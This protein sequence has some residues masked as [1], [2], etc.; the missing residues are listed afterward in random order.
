MTSPGGL[1]TLASTLAV[2][3]GERVLATLLKGLQ[4]RGV[5]QRI[6]F[7]KEPGEIGEDLGAAGIPMM[8]L[9]CRD[10][11][12][13]RILLKLTAELRRFN[14]DLLYIQ[15]HHDCLFHGRIAAALAGWL[16]ALSPVHSSA[17]GELRA[18]RLYNRV[19]LGLSPNLATLGAW[20][21]RALT[22]RERVPEGFSVTIPNPVP[23]PEFSTISRSPRSGNTLGL[24]TV[25]AMR[26]EKRLDRML[27]MVAVLAER[28]ELTLTM[29]GDGP[30]RIALEARCADLGL[31]DKVRFLGRRNDVASL[32]AE[33][34]LF[35]LS[36]D[37][38]ALPVSVLE[39]LMVGLPVAA[40]PHGAIPEL[41][42]NGERGLL[43]EGQDPRQWAE[44]LHRRLDDLPGAEDRRNWSRLL[45][46]EHSPSRF[47][48]RY[49]RYLRYLGLSR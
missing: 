29:I 36:S 5:A 17:Q 42:A 9:G 14:P 2:G 20:Q 39:A 6:V 31:A 19:L 23:G 37:E 48:T 40:P 34:D 25:A 7:L 21:E 24:V 41:L 30:E 46:D 12:D 49:L 13:P 44:Q 3:G 33:Q 27:E 1:L 4:E 38:E 10:T 8:S 28:R 18:F 11:R 32:L 22:I 16:P 15:D 47:T 43:F 35:L 45:A 26:P